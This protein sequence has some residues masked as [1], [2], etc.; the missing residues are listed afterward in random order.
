MQASHFVGYALLS[1]E[2]LL[3]C[4]F[5]QIHYAKLP[6]FEDPFDNSDHFV[7]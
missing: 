2:V 5:F 7:E 6:L 1:R 4:A 3:D